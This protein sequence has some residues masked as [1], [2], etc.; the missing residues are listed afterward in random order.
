MIVP[1]QS[2]RRI[3][4]CRATPCINAQCEKP[5]ISDPC[6]RSSALGSQISGQ[7]PI[8]DLSTIRIRNLLA[9]RWAERIETKFKPNAGWQE[10]DAIA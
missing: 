3:N 9:S 7:I 6:R 10:G 4:S 2:K 5:M 1:R 8:Q